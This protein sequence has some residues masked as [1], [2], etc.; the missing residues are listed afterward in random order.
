M[1]KSKKSAAKSTP[2][3]GLFPHNAPKTQICG[4]GAPLQQ[5]LAGKECSVNKIYCSGM[6]PSAPPTIA[7][8][9]LGAGK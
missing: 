1:A 2:A 6:P 9:S 5:G 4:C 3:P 7:Q 8:L